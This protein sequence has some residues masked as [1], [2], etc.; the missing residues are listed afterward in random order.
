M[1]A[2]R[3]RATRSDA[4][5]AEAVTQENER[6][7]WRVNF[8][9]R[10]D[11]ALEM[12]DSERE[13]R[14][15]ICAAGGSMGG[16]ARLVIL[17][18]AGRQAMDRGRVPRCQ[19]VRTGMLSISRW[20][21]VDGCCHFDD[22]R[23]DGG[24]SVCVPVRS[25]SVDL[26]VIQ[27]ALTSAPDAHEV[28]ALES[29][30]R[31]TAMK[32]ALLREHTRPRTD[33]L[34]PLTGLLERDAFEQQFDDMM[35]RREMFAMALC[36]VDGF[37]ALNDEYGHEAGDRALRR[38]G[39]ILL[40]TLRPSDLLCRYGGAEFAVLFPATSALDAAAALERVREALA[41][42]LT[43]SNEPLFTVS[44]GVADSE[45][46]ITPDEIVATA[47]MA[48]LLAKEQ[49]RNRVVIAGEETAVHLF[50]EKL[51]DPEPVIEPDILIEPDAIELDEE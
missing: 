38:F 41:L 46:G 13:L 25:S 11:R 12:V 26:G 48:L 23:T 18:P 27:I 7:Q 24:W 21:D 4:E 22:P 44:S 34:D 50:G 42:S 29:L 16:L 47:D 40:K 10:T 1:G 20:D 17:P 6:L 35:Q 3:I 30:A 51:L 19:A 36:D 37:L 33:D 15:M 45:Q 43:E 8:G 49:G 32:L 28:G 9:E 5:T 14:Q 31:R 2:Q 39:Q